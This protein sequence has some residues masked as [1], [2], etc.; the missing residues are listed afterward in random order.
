[1]GAH[2]IS[3]ATEKMQGLQKEITPLMQEQHLVSTPYKLKM[4]IN[5]KAYFNLCKADMLKAFTARKDGKLVGYLLA[6]VN[7]HLH[8][9]DH[10]VASCDM[11]YVKPEYRTSGTGYYLI[12]YAE[13]Q[14]FNLGVSIFGIN[15][16]V[17]R[18]FDK[19][20]TRMN[21]DLQERSY[22]KYIGN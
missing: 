12:K 13:E 8:Y 22:L 14:L 2:L 19:L 1:M 4:N 18:P 3:Y 15:T 11:V 21:Y 20:M 5:W 9:Q 7:T 6:F 16:R 17:D 10:L